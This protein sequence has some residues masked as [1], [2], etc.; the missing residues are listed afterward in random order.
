MMRTSHARLTAVAVAVTAAT[1]AL[2]FTTPAHADGAQRTAS[3]AFDTESWYSVPICPQPAACLPS[4]ADTYPADTLHVAVT[5]GDESA[6]TYLALPSDAVPPGSTLTGGNLKLPL[7]TLTAGSGSSAP[8]LANLQVCTTTAAVPITSGSTA[9]PPAASCVHHALAKIVGT[10]ASEL[11]VNLTPILATLNQPH[12]SLVL[13]AADIGM[14]NANWHVVFSSDTRS[15]PPVA[16]PSL[17]LTYLA[18]TTSSSGPLL[19]APTV[20]PAYDSPPG[21]TAIEAAPPLL[22]GAPTQASV[23][24]PTTA[25]AALGPA[26]VTL[27]G[28]VRAVTPLG[29]AQTKVF[30]YPAVFLLPLVLLAGVFGFGR[31]LTRPFTPR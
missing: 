2:C 18:A 15:S 13:T 19:S 25:P 20:P 17:T 11:D 22:N 29:N 3:V 28:N 23:P 21:T 14:P 8:D 30:D 9:P 26:P 24:N 31:Q 16:P 10:P 1:T 4:T 27:G 5:A 12:T 7:D 6:R